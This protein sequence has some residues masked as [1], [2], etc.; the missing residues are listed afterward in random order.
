M[1][2]IITNYFHQLN[3]C[4]ERNPSLCVFSA[5][6]K[7]FSIDKPSCASLS[8]NSCAS[9]AIIESALWSADLRLSLNDFSHSA[10]PQYLPQF[11]GILCRSSAAVHAFE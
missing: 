9:S 4:K 2:I 3:W 6:M 10:L 5:L 8:I 7:R 11:N 1:I